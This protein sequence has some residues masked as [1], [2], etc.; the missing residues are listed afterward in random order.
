M[1]T[2]KQRLEDNIVMVVLS[3]LVTGFT[4]GFGAHAALSTIPS[5]PNKSANVEDEWQNNA[6]AAGWIAKSECPAVPIVLQL[7]SPGDGTSA[8]YENGMLK[9]VL[10]VSSS[11][12]IP[13]TEA[14]GVVF[15]KEGSNDYRVVFPSLTENS[16]RTL[17]RREGDVPFP[18]SLYRDS[19]SF[20]MWGLIV[21]DKNRLGGTYGRLDQIRT[22]SESVVLSEKVTIWVHNYY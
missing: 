4:A 10:I 8:E 20:N 21:E 14:V 2:L 18:F 6:K 11:K 19:G 16:A 7:R 3:A 15:N 1:P 9:T 5:H 17:F 13:K 12:T 22:A